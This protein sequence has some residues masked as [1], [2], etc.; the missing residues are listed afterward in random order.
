MTQEGILRDWAVQVKLVNKAFAEREA[1]LKAELARQSQG[2]TEALDA[3][4]AKITDTENLLNASR[5]ELT[6]LQ[7]AANEQDARLR[8]AAAQAARASA[9]QVAN[10]ALLAQDLTQQLATLKGHEQALDSDLSA[11]RAL[12]DLAVA[13]AQEREHGL[14]VAQAT[15]EQAA[16]AAE[17]RAAQIEA[18]CQSLS[19]QI[20]AAAQRERSAQQALDEAH[21]NLAA[22]EARSHSRESNQLEKIRALELQAEQGRAAHAA[23]L[24]AANLAL[25]AAQEQYDRGLAQLQSALQEQQLQLTQ[26][27][28][29]RETALAHSGALRDANNQLL[30]RSTA[31]ERE[32]AAQ[33]VQALEKAAAGAQ[34]HVESLATRE[35]QHEERLR[36]LRAKMHTVAERGRLQ[37]DALQAHLTSAHEVKATAD[38]EAAERERSLRDDMQAMMEAD[39]ARAE[40][41]RVA[42]QQETRVYL[43]QLAERD[44]LHAAER[45]DLDTRGL[46]AAQSLAALQSRCDLAQAELAEARQQQ[47]RLQA[48]AEL[49]EQLLRSEQ[50]QQQAAARQELDAARGAWAAQQ[51]EQLQQIQG[52]TVA[53]SAARDEEARLRA[54]AAQE[55]EALKTVRQ[56]QST[57]LAAQGLQLAESLALAAQ[58][59]QEL[60]EL[61]NPAPQRRAGLF[62]RPRPAPQAL[63]DAAQA[64][65]APIAP[66]ARPL[67]SPGPTPVPVPMLPQRLAV[68][69]AAAH[70]PPAVDQP[71]SSP[72]TTYKPSD[73]QSKHISQLLA[74]HGAAFVTAA[75]RSVL[76]REPDPQGAAYFLSRVDTDHNKPAILYELATSAEGLARQQGLIGLDDLVAS[77]SPARSRLR[78][79]LNKFARIEQTS[80]RIEWAL[81]ASSRQSEER[82]QLID[83]KLA[84]LIQGRQHLDAR[85]EGRLQGLETRLT[86][87]VA[88]MQQLQVNLGAGLANQGRQNAEGLAGLAE[89]LSDGHHTQ[90]LIAE[91]LRA[92]EDMLL[93]S[94]QRT[95][96]DPVG[97]AA[98]SAAPAPAASHVALRALDCKLDASQGA[99][100][101]IQSLAFQLANSAEAAAL[102]AC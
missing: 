45:R 84:Q 9:E 41:H 58:L 24:R 63:R 85:L 59:R 94:T 21:K 30:T 14:R 101:L 60:D 92:C 13:Q 22:G 64:H 51:A 17:E 99:E 15:S 96:A 42:Q 47:L 1:E 39:L 71:V 65:I 56:S 38:R 69:H 66:I 91:R 4:A 12:H 98:P 36:A 73:T 29:Q 75:Y 93:T 10:S 67:A 6:A 79:W 31:R 16:S 62:R 78:R 70:A 54:T 19:D 53:L 80:M 72:M 50:G 37:V 102:S 86:Q 11:V 97:G 32:L 18:R 43:A 26:V 74:L 3:A 77:R 25:H 27:T 49:R 20:A 8:D 82:L 5:A 90:S 35:G 44:S 87:V 76:G 89:R 68:E 2:A 40:A 46:A 55:L 28:T 95:S 83:I 57:E 61:R 48:Q 100:A 33:V 81:A 34:K 52:L 88:S 23:E 7:Q